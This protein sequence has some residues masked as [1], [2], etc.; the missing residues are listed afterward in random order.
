MLT[1]YL[2]LDGTTSQALAFYADVLGG[3]LEFSQTFG[4]S[5]M[6]DS[7][8][9]EF[10]DRLMH[11]TL[12]LPDGKLMASDAGPWAPFAGPM[13]SCA[14]SLQYADAASGK[15]VFDALAV[16]GKVT[17]PFEKTFWA[18]GFG[19]L[20]DKFGVIWMVNAGHN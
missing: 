9:S 3:K 7:I 12:S 11:A 13:Q 1:P 8:P 19:T 10:H 14:L 4:E 18:D 6:K 15:R 16:G 17:M 20:T 5:P 2:T